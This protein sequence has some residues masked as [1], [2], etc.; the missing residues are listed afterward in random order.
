M[1]CIEHQYDASPDSTVLHLCAICATARFVMGRGEEDQLH[2]QLG[3]PRSRSTSDRFESLLYNS[4]RTAVA[5]AFIWSAQ[6]SWLRVSI[7]STFETCWSQQHVGSFG[8]T[9]CFCCRAAYVALSGRIGSDSP[10]FAAQPR[11]AVLH[12]AGKPVY[13]NLRLASPT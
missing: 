2:C 13:E 11:H 3:E 5:L 8:D 12:T 4:L 9:G 10:C 6:S 1:K 7:T